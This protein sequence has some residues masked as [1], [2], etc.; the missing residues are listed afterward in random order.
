MP[1]ERPP[2]HTRTTGFPQDKGFFLFPWMCH[3]SLY[4]CINKRILWLSEEAH[5]NF[6]SCWL[7]TESLQQQVANSIH[8][9]FVLPLNN[10][11]PPLVKVTKIF[12]SVIFSPETLK[13][14]LTL[15]SL[16]NSAVYQIWCFYGIS[17]FAPIF[18]NE[19]PHQHYPMNPISVSEA[20]RFV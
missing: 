10:C 20:V 14:N 3:H 13:G 12:L 5:S 4:S 8:S 15:L 19:L 6:K 18:K 1:G 9:L 11:L 17:W 16:W 2:Q 7:S